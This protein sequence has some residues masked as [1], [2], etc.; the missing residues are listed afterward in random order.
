MY[1]S[2]AQKTRNI[3][4]ISILVVCGLLPVLF[5]PESF[6]TSAVLK[7]FIFYLGVFL[8]VSFWFV[9]QIIEGVVRI[10]RSPAFLALATWVGLSLLSTLF[11]PNVSVSFW[12]RAFVTDSFLSILAIALFVFMISVYAK[13]QKRLVQVFLTT[14]TGAV[15]TLVAQLVLY[16]FKSVPVMER[17]FAH[18]SERG[19]LVGTWIDFSY[20]VTFTFILGLLLAEVLQPKGFFKHASRVAVILSLVVLAFINFKTAWIVA[21]VAAL[22]IFVYKSS[23]ERALERRH[24]QATS[25]S[26]DTEKRFPLL[27]FV[28]LL[29]GLFFFLTANSVGIIL[30]RSA[31]IDFIDVR[32][33]FSVSRQVFVESIKKDPLFGSGPGRYADTW[34]LYKP[35]SVNNTPLWNTSF[36]TGFNYFLSLGTTYG[37]LPLIALIALFVYSIWAGLSSSRI[38]FKTDSLDL[39][40]SLL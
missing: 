19:T 7:G 12:G 24:Q 31:Q 10:P 1:N 40:L 21:I 34:N 32:P 2:I 18:V 38:R 16:V 14:F 27:S 33:S 4:F 5:L 36:D 8:S 13:E 6:G 37:I 26:D 28:S 35:Q 15:V 9:S 20:F 29:F 39:L 22:F 25:V 17:L 11:S 3:S 23:V 30:S